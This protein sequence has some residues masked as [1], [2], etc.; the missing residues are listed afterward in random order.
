[1]PTAFYSGRDVWVE[2]RRR[3]RNSKEVFAAISYIGKGAS[4]FLPLRR[5]D[6]LIVDLS[7]Q[8]VA[9]GVTDPREV[10]KFLRRGVHVFTRRSLH[11]KFLL[12]DDVIVVGSANA[13]NN[14]VTYLDEAALL[15]TDRA[16]RR[17]AKQ[18]IAAWSTEP[19]RP[20][21]LQECI[22]AY[23]P[24]RFK[25]AA[26]TTLTRSG[27]RAQTVKLWL[28]GG[29]RYKDIPD[30][31]KEKAEAA[32]TRAAA[33]RRRSRGTDVNQVHYSAK[34]LLM[35]AMRPGDWAVTC[36]H[37]AR[38]A[39]VWPPQQLLSIESYPRGHGRRRWVF[40]FEALKNGQ[41][42]GLRRFQKAV[43]RALDGQWS[44]RRSKAIRSGQSADAILRLWD[45]SGQ[46]SR[47]R[48]GGAR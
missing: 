30:T 8:A 46:P 11:A 14:S 44:G 31:E 5:G 4:V 24:P 36:I 26:D 25:A 18:C 42:I 12:I 22:A 35:S 2:I 19:V 33:L 34:T 20:R 43:R 40:Q 9:Q 28:V 1:M 29:L 45:Q 10:A 7:L 39:H 47:R 16:A 41:H 37:D 17:F 3:L 15:T 32:I 13:S 38:G 27:G 48:S 21:Y 23:R 6:T